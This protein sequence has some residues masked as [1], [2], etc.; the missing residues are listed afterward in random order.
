SGSG[1]NGDGGNGSGSGDNGDG[2]LEGSVDSIYDTTPQIYNVYT[3]SGQKVMQTK[4]YSDL[5]KLAPG[6][7]IVNGKKIQMR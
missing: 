4:E 2:D 7:Y 3:L 1:D 5:Q 6:I